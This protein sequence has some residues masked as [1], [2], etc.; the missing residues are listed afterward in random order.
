MRDIETADL[1]SGNLSKDSRSENTVPKLLKIKT[2]PEP[3]SE[4]RERNVVGSF[5]FSSRDA[6]GHTST[7]ISIGV[8]SVTSLEP[9]SE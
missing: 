2:I 5:I 4:V 6:I 8:A 7:V 1:S 9:R 3:Q